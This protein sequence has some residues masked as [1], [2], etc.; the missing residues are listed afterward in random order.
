[1][2][3]KLHLIVKP[4]NIKFN[5]YL[6]DIFVERTF[7]IQLVGVIFDQKHDVN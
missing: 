4:N 5:G 7:Y 6:V 2:K 3:Y 1:M